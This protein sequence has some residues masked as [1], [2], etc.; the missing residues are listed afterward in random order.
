MQPIDLIYR[1]DPANPDVKAPPA[2]AEEAR[3]TLEKGNRL[4]ARWVDS[5]TRDHDLGGTPPS[6]VLR[7]SPLDLG[8]ASAEGAAAIQT[9]F[10][11]L[12]GCADARV[13]AEVIFGQ[14]RN[15]L[16]VVRVAGNVLSDECLGSIEYALGN[17]SSIRIVV[18]LGH[19]GCGA[20]TAAVDTYLDPRAYLGA[21]TS[22]ALRKI[23]DRLFVPVRASVEALKTVWGPY[24]SQVAGY[25]EVLIETAV[26]FNVLLS[27]FNLRQSIAQFGKKDVK[28]VYGVFDLVSHRV[29]TVPGGDIKQTFREVVLADA[30]ASLEELVELGDRAAAWAASR[31]ERRA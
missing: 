18:V 29:W 19:T 22:P 5:C 9:P 16:F 26:V 8:L 11:A 10:A 27:A 15:N 17:M 30:P 23:L 14:L 2:D 20:V 31:V 25:R 1:F 24:P 3:Q 28:V 4:F 13:P 6:L 21:S 12:L 7:C